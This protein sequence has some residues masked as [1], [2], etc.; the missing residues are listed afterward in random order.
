MSKTAIVLE[1]A[2]HERRV[3]GFCGEIECTICG[4]IFL[5]SGIDRNS[6]MSTFRI[7]PCGKYVICV[8]AQR[9]D[10]ALVESDVG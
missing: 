10:M 2:R 6:R 4:I 8:V 3:L 7:R 1:C 5:R 9:W